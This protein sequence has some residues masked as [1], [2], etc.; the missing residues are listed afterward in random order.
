MLLKSFVCFFNLMRANLNWKGNS[1]AEIHS[2]KLVVAWLHRLTLS[3]THKIE[4]GENADDFWQI[5]LSSGF[6]THV[7]HLLELLQPQSKIR[8]KVWPVN[9]FFHFRRIF[10]LCVSLNFV[11]LLP[12][13]PNDHRRIYCVTSPG[14]KT[15]QTPLHTK[16]KQISGMCVG[17]FSSILS[18]T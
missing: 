16:C 17:S 9:F 4:V 10:Y 12:G 6:C 13:L 11:S 1:N 5:K 2:L 14:H 18:L 7:Q 15:N 8:W 3:Y